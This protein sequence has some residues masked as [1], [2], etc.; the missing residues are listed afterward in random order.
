MV[1]TLTNV[2]A[3]SINYADTYTSGSGPS[4]IVAVGGNRVTPLPYPFGHVGTVLSMGT[5]VMP[6]HVADFRYKPVPWLPTEP[7]SDWQFLVQAGI[8]T[9]GVAVEVAYTD[10][11]DLFTH[12]I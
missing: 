9:L 12:E 1:V 8:V 4:G 2:S 3:L 5:S 7:A 10:V 11:E 6:V